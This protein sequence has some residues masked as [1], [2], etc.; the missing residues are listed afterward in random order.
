MSHHF[1][2]TVNDWVQQAGIEFAHPREIVG[3]RPIVLGVVSIDEAQ[4]AGIGDDHFMAELAQGADWPRE[5]EC[6]PPAQVGRA[7]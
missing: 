3:I 5:N 1:F 6:R 2:A 7:A 4:H